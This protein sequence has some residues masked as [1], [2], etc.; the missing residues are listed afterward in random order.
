MNNLFA[1]LNLSCAVD[2]VNSSATKSIV[3]DF[4]WTI[5]ENGVTIDSYTGNSKELNIPAIIDDKP[6]TAIGE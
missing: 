3:A 6:V 2:P 1:L 5:S 4:E